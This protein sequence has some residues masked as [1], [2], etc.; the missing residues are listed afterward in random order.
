MLWIL[1]FG[2]GA[3]VGSF[4]NVLIHRLPRENSIVR[5]GSK[6]PACEVPIRYYDNIP[7]LSYIFLRGR[8]RNCGA[9]ISIR[10]P[11]VEAMAGALLV[12]G[13]LKFGLSPKMGINLLLALSLLAVAFIDL[14]HQLI[15]NEISLPGIVLGFGLSFFLEGKEWWEAPLSS[16]IGGI[17]GATALWVIRFLHMKI[18]GIEGMGL[19]DVKLIAMI[20][21]FLGWQALPSLL[22]I[23]A[24]SGLLIG[25]GIILLTRKAA[26]TPIPFGTFL[27]AGTITYI[28]LEAEIIGILLGLR[29]WIIY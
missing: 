21:A 28:F 8:C 4:L 1:L 3:C 20:G 29:S 11:I 16:L 17:S 13:Y 2:F 5:P 14:E 26:R 19:G 24:F 27:A 15:P 9:R 12:L 6:C 18:S 22:F 7:I 25:G 23:S 10:Y